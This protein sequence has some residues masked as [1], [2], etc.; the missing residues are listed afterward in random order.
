MYKNLILG[1]TLLAALALVSAP[2]QADALHGFCT[3]VTC[4]DNGAITPVPSSS[5][6]FGFWDAS[7]PITGTDIVVVLS[8]TNVGGAIALNPTNVTGTPPTS[9][10]LLPTEWTSGDLD[11][12]LGLSASPNNPF[13]NYGGSGGLD[14]GA[15]GF[16]VYELNLGSQTAQNQTNELNGPLFSAT[17]LAPGTFILDFVGGVAT[18]NSAALE[19]VGT[20]PEPSSLL[21][22]GTGL[23]GMVGLARRRF[24]NS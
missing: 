17:G 18:A 20:A 15:T 21:L 10:T 7:G 13:G 14:A 5:P 24:Q 16:F 2:A 23:L 3:N 19:I 11:A 12:F 22:L 9:A 4:S 1:V 8:L 6:S